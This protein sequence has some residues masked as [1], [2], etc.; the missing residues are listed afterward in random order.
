MK[1]IFRAN[2]IYFPYIQAVCTATLIYMLFQAV[3]YQWWLLSLGMY[4]LTGCLGITITFHR[5][6]TH[7]SFKFRYKWME[8]LFSFFGA[9]GGTGSSIGWVAVHNEHHK[10]ADKDGDPHSPHNGFWSVIIPKY[11]FEM[12]KWAVRRLITDKFHLV[13]HNYYYLTLL[14]WCAIL[15]ILG[16]LNVLIFAGII[17]V[18]FQLW[19]SVLSN[20]GN[21]MW[22]Y[23][24]FKTKEDSRNT[25]WLAAIT[26]GEGWHNNHHAKP[27]RWDFQHRWWELDPSA[28]VIRLVKT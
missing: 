10:N 24:N 26:W 12:N 15:F 27:G 21:H 16:G 4:F 1:N 14:V 6:L 13:L 3:E 8:Y 23:R 22:G 7:N 20:Y 17:P 19:A 2:T 5:Y 25:W 9:I 11:E 28:W 18:A